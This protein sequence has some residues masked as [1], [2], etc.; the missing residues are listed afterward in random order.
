MILTNLTLADGQRAR[1][2][3]FGHWRCGD[4]RRLCRDEVC[5]VGHDAGLGLEHHQQG[6]P[7]GNSLKLYTFRLFQ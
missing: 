6:G 7:V 1:Y 2:F 3:V 5:A 4:E